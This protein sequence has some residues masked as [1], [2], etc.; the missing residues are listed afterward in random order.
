MEDFLYVL[1]M[2]KL[3][4]D[5]SDHCIAQ[6]SYPHFGKHTFKIPFNDTIREHIHYIPY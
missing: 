1:W 6:I 4:T 2:L 3:F 5:K